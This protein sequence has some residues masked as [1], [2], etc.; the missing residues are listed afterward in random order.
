MYGSNAPT[1]S[2]PEA[3]HQQPWKLLQLQRT[4]TWGAEG[5]WAILTID[6]ISKK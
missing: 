1:F 2:T 5:G 4:F 6:V 3:L